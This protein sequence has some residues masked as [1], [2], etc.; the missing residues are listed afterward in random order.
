MCLFVLPHFRIACLLAWIVCLCL[1]G[2]VTAQERGIGVTAAAPAGE[3]RVALVIGNSAY[4]PALGKLVNPA[5]DAADMARTLAGLGF[6]VIHKSDLDRRG[7]EEALDQ[8]TARAQGAAVAL[9]YYAGHGVQV[10]QENFL[11]PLRARMRR[12]LDARYEAMPANKVVD[13]MQSSG[14]R[15]N[16]VILDA[17][18][19]NPL[20]KSGRSTGS[21][22][23]SMQAAA[24]TLIAFAAGPGETA[25]ENP[26]GRNG[27]YTEELLK[28][29]ATPGL[30]IVEA[31]QRTREGVH[32]RSRRKQTPQDWNQL[33]G[34]IVLAK[35]G[36]EGFTAPP[37]A[38]APKPGSTLSLDDITKAAQQEKESRAAWDKRLGEMKNAYAQVET[39]GRDT[40]SPEIKQ[41]AWAR[42]LAAFTQDNP[43]S[44]EDEALRGI[45][46]ERERHW[47]GTIEADSAQAW[48]SRGEE[49]FENGKWTKPKQARDYYTVAIEREPEFAEAHVQRARLRIFHFQEYEQGEADLRQALRL[50]PNL[51]SAHYAM[52]NLLSSQEKNDIKGAIAAYTRAIELDSGFILAYLNRGVQ[53]ARKKALDKAIADYTAATGSEDAWVRAV[54]HTNRGI[55]YL[56]LERSKEAMADFNAAIRE[57]PTFA[58]AYVERGKLRTADKDHDGA[59][60]DFSAAIEHASDF[61]EAYAFRGDNYNNHQRDYPAAIRDFTRAIELTPNWAFAVAA[62]GNAKLNNKDYDAALADVNKAL[63]LQPDYAWALYIRGRVYERQGRTAKAKTD[64][65]RACDLGYKPACGK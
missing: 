19:N 4:G 56:N 14:A 48:F 3:R 10:E 54:A 33:V 27:L 1:P 18:R 30:S 21:G 24:G 53:Y 17:C 52:G 32:R 28:N 51:A 35:A 31:F 61:A 44:T 9:F 45:A 58:R 39:I 25:D 11:V 46:N 20:P 59:L 57:A 29:L 64:W 22:L 65:R 36:S 12:Q 23:A 41:A 49:L 34:S 13:Y 15:A 63:D 16:I 43:Y 40:V 6:D 7:M 55:T 60:A 50:A 62:R 26:G 5:N 42:F 37:V 47:K 2:V 8:F 38:G